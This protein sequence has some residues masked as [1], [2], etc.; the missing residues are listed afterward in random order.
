[1]ADVKPTLEGKTI[2]LGISGGIA[3]Y[4]CCELTRLLVKRGAGVH[5]IMTKAAC[6]FVTPLTMEVLSGNPVHC[7]MFGTIEKFE[8]GHISL[9]KRANALLVVPATADII[10]KIAG[11]ICDEL[12]TATIMATT[13]PVIVCPSMNANMWIKPAL[14]GNLEKLK[15]FGFKIIEPE[16]GTLVCG[17]EGRGRLP[18]LEMIIEKLED[19]LTL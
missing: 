2:V 4:K 10:A 15:K 12:L 13:A 19:I 9:A 7:Q 11:G 18:K 6:E 14:Q 5:V 17:A 16:A 8:A 1:M 3:A